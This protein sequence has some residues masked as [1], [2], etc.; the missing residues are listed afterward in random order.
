MRGELEG[1]D[2]EL[3]ECHLQAAAL[4]CNWVETSFVCADPGPGGE[5]I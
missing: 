3:G 1:F 4:K 2:A 5:E